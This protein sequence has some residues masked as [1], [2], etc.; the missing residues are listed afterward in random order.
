MH[1][2]FISRMTCAHVFITGRVQGV[3]FRVYTKQEAEALGLTGWVRNL[4][5]GRVEAVFEGAKEKVEEMIKWCWEGSTSA[6]VSD[7]EVSWEEQKRLEGFE[8]KR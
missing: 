2:Y 8:I 3:F 7:V 5:D 1:V 4:A 6:N